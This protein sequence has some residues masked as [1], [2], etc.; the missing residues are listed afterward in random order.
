MLHGSLLAGAISSISTPTISVEFIRQTVLATHSLITQIEQILQ[1][2]NLDA[3]TWRSK[4]ITESADHPKC[5]IRK[6][7]TFAANFGC[8]VVPG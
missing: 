6:Q 5:Q 3:A 1:E 4:E 7:S 2:T 8:E